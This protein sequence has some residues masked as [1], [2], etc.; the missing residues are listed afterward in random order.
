MV[1]GSREL[2]LGDGK[3]K[4]PLD[5]GGDIHYACLKQILLKEKK[6]MSRDK[7]KVEKEID[8]YIGQVIM[9]I[10]HIMRNLRHSG[11]ELL[12]E[13]E[14]SYPQILLLY[15]LLENG[16][17]SISEISQRLKITQGVVSRM[18][19]RLVEKGIVERTRD[20]ED[21]RVVYVSLSKKG[22][23][24]AERMITYHVDRLKQKFL[25]VKKV[26]RENFL[27]LLQDID[28]QLEE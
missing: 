19:E 26:D 6:F 1:S 18:V 12:S 8:E 20:K 16:P 21:R 9:V 27:K 25:K 10:L 3:G 7:S 4:K 15:A 13:V 5:R 14:L 11:M 24:H 2:W 17:S 28:S 23:D 22:R